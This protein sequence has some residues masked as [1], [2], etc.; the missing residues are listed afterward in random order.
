VQP[1]SKYNTYA[2]YSFRDSIN[3]SKQSMNRKIEMEF[4]E[5]MQSLLPKENDKCCICSKNAIYAWRTLNI[6]SKDNPWSLKIPEKREEQVCVCQNCLVNLFREK[7]QTEC[8]SFKYVYPIVDE[9]GYY[10]PWEA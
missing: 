4:D 8:I 5:Y 10:T 1:S 6:Y 2:F 9:I 7:M 3:A